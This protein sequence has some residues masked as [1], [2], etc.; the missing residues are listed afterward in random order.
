MGELHVLKPEDYRHQVI[1]DTNVSDGMSVTSEIP[2]QAKAVTSE[3]TV[4]PTPVTGITVTRSMGLTLV[5][6]L[7]L[8]F[9]V[10]DGFWVFWKP[11]QTGHASWV[12]LCAAI[13]AGML[14]NQRRERFYSQ[15][16]STPTLF[17]S[18]RRCSQVLITLLFLSVFCG[19]MSW[20]AA[21]G[22]AAGNTIN[23]IQSQIYGFNSVMF[24]T[25][26]L[27]FYMHIDVH[28]PVTF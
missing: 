8:G 26:S 19:A 10:A 16:V 28:S 1:C 5:G 4:F 3:P 11:I 17:V 13:A 2:E 9:M 15:E 18:N 24:L 22:L 25:A 23:A 7:F 6:A 21:G 14:V 12:V 20:L 27:I